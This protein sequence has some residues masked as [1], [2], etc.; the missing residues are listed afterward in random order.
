MSK[1][2]RQLRI[3]FLSFCAL[4]LFFLIPVALYLL[5]FDTFDLELLFSTFGIM[6]VAFFLNKYV[7]KEYKEINNMKWEDD[8]LYLWY[9]VAKKRYSDKKEKW[10]D[11]IKND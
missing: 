4:G 7:N 1:S 9:K 6:V 8:S 3:I 5:I 2:F 11:E 10:K